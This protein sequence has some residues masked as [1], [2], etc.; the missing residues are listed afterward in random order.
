L[1]IGDL[2]IGDA[3]RQECGSLE[4]GATR[5][6]RSDAGVAFGDFS[7]SHIP[8]LLQQDAKRNLETKTPK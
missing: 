2:G 8:P 7:F 5:H 6:P 1:G 4:Q 3:G